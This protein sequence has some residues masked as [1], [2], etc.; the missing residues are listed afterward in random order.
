M[1]ATIF[2]K[3]TAFTTF[4]GIMLFECALL[5]YFAETDKE[6]V[7]YPLLLIFFTFIIFFAF[8]IKLYYREIIILFGDNYFS[9]DYHYCPR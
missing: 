8:I 3:Y 9:I 1:K 7:G 6:L 2:N 5:I 4:C